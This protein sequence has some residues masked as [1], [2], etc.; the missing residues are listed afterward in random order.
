MS[1]LIEKRDERTRR[2]KR[3]KRKMD[4]IIGLSFHDKDK[5]VMSLTVEPK[6]LSDTRARLIDEGY[7]DNGFV[8][9]KG[10]LEKYLNGENQYVRGWEFDGEEWHQTE[11]LNLNSDFVGTVNLGHMDFAQMPFILGEWRKDDLTLVDIENDRK[12]LDVELHLD[13]DS[14]FI[15][16][17]KRQSHDIGISAE[18]WVHQNDEDTEN[19][20]ETLGYYLPVFDEIYIFAYGLVGECG[21]VNSSGLELKGEP[22]EDVKENIILDEPKDEEELGVE[23]I[24]IPTD[25]PKDEPIEETAEEAVAEDNESVEDEVAEE[26]E[27]AESEEST[28]GEE[29]ADEEAVE[30]DGDEASDDEAE[31]IEDADEEELAIV[32]ELREQIQTLTNR[33]SE[34]EEANAK[35]KKTNRKLSSKHQNELDKKAKFIETLKGL[36]VELLPDEEKKP[37][38][39]KMKVMDRNYVRD[40]IGE[41]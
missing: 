12:A 11:V 26:A 3:M 13:E 14:V 2:R 40:G 39:E 16:E 31:E 8:I 22:M 15:K 37:K 10:T 5:K 29:V 28:E 41:I 24:E 1:D 27:E 7:I 20:S 19:L 9:K 4:S 36:S 25:E 18:F 32:T 30:E 6:K 17:L 33:I 23:E 21:N 38:E 35:L 34:L